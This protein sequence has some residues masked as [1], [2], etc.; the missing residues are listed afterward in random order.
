LHAVNQ[1]LVPPPDLMTGLFLFPIHFSTMQSALQKVGLKD[2]IHDTKAITVFTPTNHAFARLGYRTLAYLFSPHGEEYLK[3]ILTYHVSPQL[4]YSSD[5]LKSENEGSQYKRPK[6]GHFELDTLEGSKLYL[7]TVQYGDRYLRIKINGES[8]VWFTD[9]IG[10]NG[11]AHIIDKVL[12]P[13]NCQ[14]PNLEEFDD[15]DFD[16]EFNF[17]L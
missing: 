4:V 2:V 15:F 9:G 17:S 3:R 10:K 11:V 8:R 13:S 16:G 14:M 6:Q 1:I 12:I 7:Y 5:L